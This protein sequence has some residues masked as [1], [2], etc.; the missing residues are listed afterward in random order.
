VNDATGVYIILGGIVLAVTAVGVW[1]WLAE[2][3]R[4]RKKEQ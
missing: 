2:R 4:V 1:D 3:D